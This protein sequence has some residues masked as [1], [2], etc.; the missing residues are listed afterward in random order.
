MVNQVRFLSP[1]SPVV[2]FSLYCR[3]GRRRTT[4]IP[5]VLL[6]IF[7]LVVGV[8]P[9]VYVYAVSQFIVGAALGG[10]RINSVVLGKKNLIKP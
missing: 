4:Q 1:F 9:N 8:S 7:V 3:F 2:Y 10:Y 5:V 6:V